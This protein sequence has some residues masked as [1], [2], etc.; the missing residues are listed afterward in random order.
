MKKGLAFIIT[1]ILTVFIQIYIVISSLASLTGKPVGQWFDYKKLAAAKDYLN[2]GKVGTAFDTAGQ[3]SMK[4]LPLL[5][6]F[7]KFWPPLSSILKRIHMADY[8]KD[9]W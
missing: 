4:D 6:F 3:F 8:F 9:F 2:S 7:E 5:S 1:F